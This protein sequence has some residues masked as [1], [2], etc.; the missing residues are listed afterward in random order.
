MNTSVNCDD[1]FSVLLKN[2]IKIDH[3]ERTRMLKDFQVNYK[4]LHM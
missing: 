4:I 2:H 3:I 1:L